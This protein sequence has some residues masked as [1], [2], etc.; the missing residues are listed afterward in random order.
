MSYLLSLSAGA[1][2]DALAAGGAR[3]RALTS[4]IQ[5]ITM[6]TAQR[7]F[8]VLTMIEGATIPPL[9]TPLLAK[10]PAL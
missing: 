6:V 10:E 1:G 3:A 8:S 5:K 4:T 9:A 2:A 7:P